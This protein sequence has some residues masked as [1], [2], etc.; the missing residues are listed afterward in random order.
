MSGRN[1]VIGLTGA[2]DGNNANIFERPAGADEFVIWSV[3]T[4]PGG[5]PRRNAWSGIHTRLGA[6]IIST[7]KR[8]DG[9]IVWD[10]FCATAD[11]PCPK[12]IGDLTAG[13]LSKVGPFNMPPPCI[14]V[15][16]STSPTATEPRVTAGSIDGVELLSAFHTCFHGLDSEINYVDFDVDVGEAQTRRRTTVRRAGETQR[17]SEMAPIRRA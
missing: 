15:F 2:M 5:D 17:V 13:R 10:F 4:N 6:E 8:V 1:A 11:R 16:P 3:S 12:V 9:L 14:Y 7:G